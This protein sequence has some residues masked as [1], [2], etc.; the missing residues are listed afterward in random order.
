[1]ISDIKQQVQMGAGP[2][3]IITEPMARYD[4]WGGGGWLAVLKNL[5]PVSLLLL[6]LFSWLG[7]T[8]ADFGRL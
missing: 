6:L 2:H 5:H 1:M 4:L 7:P 8:I 3:F